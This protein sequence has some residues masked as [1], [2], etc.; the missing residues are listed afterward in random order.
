MTVALGLTYLQGRAGSGA[1]HWGVIM[2]VRF[3]AL[4]QCCCFIFGAKIFRTGF[5]QSG[6][7]RIIRDSLQSS[8]HLFYT[9]ETIYGTDFWRT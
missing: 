1:G 9:K 8:N 5:D 4:S 7:E 3:W 2:A 6:S